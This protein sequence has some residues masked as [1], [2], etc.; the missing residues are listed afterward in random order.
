MLLRRLG[1]ALAAGLVALVGVAFL[2]AAA[3]LWL[4]SVLPRAAAAAVVGGAL[5]AIAILLLVAGAA[6]RRAEPLG[7]EQLVFAALRLTARS[8]QAAPEKALIAALIAGVLSEWF[9][10]RKDSEPR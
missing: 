8:V 3:Y 9:G 10:T 4:A 1:L 5:V 2:V 6:R 7:P